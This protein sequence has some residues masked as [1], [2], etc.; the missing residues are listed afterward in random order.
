MTSTNTSTTINHKLVS[1]FQLLQKADTT[2]KKFSKLA[3]LYGLLQF[4]DKR[5][6]TLHNDFE[7]NSEDFKQLKFFKNTTI[8]VTFDS[9]SNKD[10]E[11]VSNT[12]QKVYEQAKELLFT[13]GEV[14]HS[15]GN[16]CSHDHSED[17]LDKMLGNK[18]IQ[19]MLKKK[20][21]RQKLQQTLGKQFNDKNA[22]LEDMIK[23]VMKD[24][25][26]E[27]QMNMVNGLLS[28]PMVKTLS[29]KLMN[30]DNIGK[31]KDIFVNFIASEEVA[32]EINNIR[33]VFNEDKIFAVATKM[34]EQVQSLDDMTKVQG[35]IENN[36]DLQQIIK[37]FENAISSGLINQDKI[38]SLAQ[39]GTD[40][41]MKEFKS[42][43]ILDG[44]NMGMLSTLMGQFGGDLLGNTKPEKKT[45]K[46]DRRAKAQKKYR[47]QQ[48][49]QRK[50]LKGRRNK[51]RS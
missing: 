36:K 51:K 5:L 27:E 46:A 38:M 40:Y 7:T 47:R 8:D 24:Q 41:F 48:R 9:L 37:T 45:S 17:H 35:L 49:E 11:F 25:M 26:P 22:S 15:C 39:K 1:I 31:I 34:F 2:S 33:S 18:K 3:K 50:K 19:K 21:V 10:Q 14:A 29:D 6:T 32:E 20:G 28:N 42:L 16:D 44:A 13:G 4:N 43:G 30:D 12:L 23:N